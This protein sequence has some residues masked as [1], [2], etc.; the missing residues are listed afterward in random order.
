MRKVYY[1]YEMAAYQQDER[2][3]SMEK[4]LIRVDSQD[5]N[6]YSTQAKAEKF[7]REE[8]KYERL[9][10]SKRYT[11]LPVYIYIR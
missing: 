4:I 6:G 2:L 11:V 3:I 8:V 10:T 9:D 7:I 5:D 1:V